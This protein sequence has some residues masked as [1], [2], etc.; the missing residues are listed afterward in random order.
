[1][2]RGL[3]IADLVRDEGMRTEIYTDTVG[4]ITVGV[5]RNLTDNGI[6]KSESDL[7]LS[8]DIDDTEAELDSRIPWWRDLP[9]DAQ[10][11]LANM[12]FNLGWPRLSKFVNMLA[13]LEA[14]SYD[15]AADAALDSIWAEQVGERAIRI[16]ELLRSA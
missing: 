7:M 2:N 3:L 1:M 6:R 12:C 15:N 14:G 9:A 4:K 16:A 11:A 5:G 10:R 13:A 8:N